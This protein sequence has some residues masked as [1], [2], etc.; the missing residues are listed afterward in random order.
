MIAAFRLLPGLWQLGIIAGALVALVGLYSAWHYTVWSRGYD[1]AIYAIAKKDK[2][3]IDAA[4]K[5]SKAVDACYDASRV[6]DDTRGVC[7]P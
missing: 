1:A 2:G 4:D 3:A 5:I 6:W 7:L